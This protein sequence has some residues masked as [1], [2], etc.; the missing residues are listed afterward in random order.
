MSVGVLRNC[1]T[2]NPSMS[3]YVKTSEAQLHWNFTAAQVA[4]STSPN[5]SLQRLCPV[6]ILNNDIN[7]G[8]SSQGKA[9]KMVPW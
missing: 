3:L 8:R 4:P 9:R 5:L 7:Q 1:K 2:E 6:V